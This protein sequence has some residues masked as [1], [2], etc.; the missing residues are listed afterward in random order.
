MALCITPFRLDHIEFTPDAEKKNIVLCHFTCQVRCTTC[1]DHLILCHVQIHDRHSTRFRNSNGIPSYLTVTVI[2][3]LKV[4]NHVPYPVGLTQFVCVWKY[5]FHVISLRS[6]EACVIKPTVL[7]T[8]TER[9]NTCV[10]GLSSAV[11]E[12]N[13]EPDSSSVRPGASVILSN[14]HITSSCAS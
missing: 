10:I 7:T 4:L 3:F 9:I 14:H 11:C 6:F 12:V 8:S 5:C 2:F 13:L 1:N